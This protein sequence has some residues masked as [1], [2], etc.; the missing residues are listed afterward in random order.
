MDQKGPDF[1]DSRDPIFSDFR[2]PM[3]IFSHSMDTIFNYRKILESRI[4]CLK[5][6]KKNDSTLKLFPVTRGVKNTSTLFAI[7]FSPLLLRAFPSISGVLLRFRSSAKLFDLS[8]FRAGLRP[9]GCLCV[10]HY[11]LTTQPSSP[12]VFQMHKYCAI[13]LLSVH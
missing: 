7:Y 12:T 8:R 10:N 9:V 13:L 1:S 11:M 4:G 2:D 5:R 3:I 6:I